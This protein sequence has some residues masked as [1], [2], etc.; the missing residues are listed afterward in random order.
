MKWNGISLSDFWNENKKTI[1][2]FCLDDSL[3]FTELNMFVW[4]NDIWD[5]AINLSI[6]VSFFRMLYTR[7]QTVDRKI[8]LKI[9]Y[10]VYQNSGICSRIIRKFL[11][12]FSIFSLFKCCCRRYFK[13]IET[14]FDLLI[15]FRRLLKFSKIIELILLNESRMQMPSYFFFLSCMRP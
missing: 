1:F 11:S 13:D 3:S 8:I 15:K 4:F 2:C 14:Y 9:Q 5:V 6:A 7:F 12:N 10:E